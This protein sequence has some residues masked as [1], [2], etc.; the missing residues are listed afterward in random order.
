[1]ADFDPSGSQNPWN[2]FDEAWHGWLRSVPHLT[3]QLWWGTATWVVWANMW[4]ITSL[5]FLSFLSFFAFFQRAPRLHF[6]TDR[7][8]LYAKMRVSGQGCAFWGSRQYPT[9]FRVSNP[10]KTSPKWAGIGIF[11]PNQ[12]SS[13]I[14]EYWSLM[15]ILASNFTERLITGS[16]TGWV[17]ALTCY[18]SQSIKHRNYQRNSKLGQRGSWRGHVTYF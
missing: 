1:M 10:Q 6:L 17:V 4:L 3:W 7:D 2:D 15:K 12:R 11:Q 13:K 5:S 16:I 18:I 14:D 9:T 8:D